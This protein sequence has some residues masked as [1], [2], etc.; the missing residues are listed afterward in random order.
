MV[1]KEYSSEEIKK[2]VAMLNKSEEKMK[3]MS[4]IK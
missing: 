4:I 3:N 1:E 2:I